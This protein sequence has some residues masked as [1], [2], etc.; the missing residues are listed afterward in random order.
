MF[1]KRCKRPFEDPKTNRVKDELI[2]SVRVFLPAGELVVD[3]Q[4]HTFFEALS[5]IGPKTD[6]VTHRLQAESHVEVFRDGRLGPELIAPI[7]ILIRDMLHCRPAQNG[8]VANKG[9]DI[10]VSNSKCDGGV[11]QIGKESKRGLALRKLISSIAL[12]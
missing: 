8:I 7:F 1:E 6:N 5:L 2:A 10:S 4:G 3:S 9:S 11:D 12:T